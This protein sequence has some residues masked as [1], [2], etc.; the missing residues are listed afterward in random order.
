MSKPNAYLD[1]I[2]KAY[3]NVKK[4]RRSTH[5]VTIIGIK[6][7]VVLTKAKAGQKRPPVSPWWTD[8]VQ[9]YK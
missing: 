4:D 5:C 6:M 8:F 1:V 3:A 2:K 9:L 7:F